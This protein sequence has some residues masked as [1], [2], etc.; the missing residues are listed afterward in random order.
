MVLTRSL[1]KTPPVPSTPTTKRKAPVETAETTAHFT[2]CELNKLEFT[3]PSSHANTPH[4]PLN[5]ADSTMDLNQLADLIK[6]NTV[7]FQKLSTNLGNQRGYCR[8]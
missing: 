7:E 1:S 5:P 6:S 4:I 8:N 3:F 2:P